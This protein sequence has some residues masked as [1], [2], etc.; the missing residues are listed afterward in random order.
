M[1][2]RGARRSSSRRGPVD[3]EGDDPRRP[4]LP[5]PRRR[6]RRR[7]ARDRQLVAQG[8]GLRGHRRRRRR[9]GA[10][11]RPRPAAGPAAR[12]RDDARA[13]RL[14]RLP[15]DPGRERDAAPG[16]L[17][18]RAHAHRRARRGPRRRRRRLHRQAVRQRGAGGARARR[19]AHEGGPRRA[20]RAGRARRADRRLQPPRA[21]R[22]RRARR[23]R[24]PIRHGRP[25]SCLLLDLDHFK[26]VNDTYGHAAGDT[27][28]REA[29]QRICD[30]VCGSRTSSAAT[31]A[32]SSSSCC[33]RP[34]ATPAVAA[35]D[36]LRALLADE[37]VAVGRG[38]HPDPREHRRRHLGLRRCGR[39]ATSTPPRTRR[40]TAP[41]GSAATAPS[42]TSRSPPARRHVGSGAG[43]RHGRPTDEALALARELP[44]DPRAAARDRRASRGVGSSPL[45]FRT[46]GTPEDRDVAEYAAGELRDCG[47]RDVAI[48]EVKVDGWR[49]EGA[50]LE[51][52]GDR[53]EAS[54]MGGV[55]PTPRGGL[56]APLV[57][58]G[59]AQPRRLDRLDLVGAIALVDWKREALPL[60][61]IALELGLRGRDRRRRELP[62]G[63][64]LLPVPGRHRIVRRPLARRRAADDPDR[65]GGRRGAARRAPGA[66]DD[67][68]ARRALARR[69]RRQRRRLPGGRD[70]R[71]RRSSSAPTTTAGSG[72]P[73]TTP[74][75]SRRCSRSPRR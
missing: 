10:P 66:R 68:A 46:T 37:P 22:P 14:R 60:C 73:S 64:G 2:G 54:S 20:R 24:W 52:V 30:V 59:A 17:P 39:R 5:R 19:A 47:L 44:I 42:C 41:R 21:R 56:E 45:G 40:S 70:R 8:R 51:A 36:K 25:F 53:I 67:D 43:A 65:Q 34:A 48:E 63:R 71:R 4:A 35:A 33:P 69:P 38:Q 3:S 57:D 16:D 49:F 32:R 26:Q 18:D 75:A 50:S 27:V 62:A 15:G 58:A 29:A 31:A 9:P 72:P 6:R 61:D 13:R 55:P 7:H 23:S 11:A 1:S 74:R 12:R 28:L